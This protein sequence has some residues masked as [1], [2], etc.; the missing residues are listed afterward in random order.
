MI[1]VNYFKRL[2]C[3]CLY[4]LSTILTLL[5]HVTAVTVSK[6]GL[7][8]GRMRLTE[9]IYADTSLVVVVFCLLIPYGYCMHK[10]IHSVSFHIFLSDA[11][12]MAISKLS[13]RYITGRCCS[14]DPGAKS[15][16]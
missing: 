3:G 8:L 1:F 16:R 4:S 10:E 5:V 6:Y 12:D 13:V 7:E 9:L 15:R 14:S 2:S 11:R